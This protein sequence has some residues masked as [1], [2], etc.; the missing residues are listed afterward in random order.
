MVE[1]VLFICNSEQHATALRRVLDGTNIRTVGLGC[2]LIGS[3]FDVIINLVSV[4]SVEERRKEWLQ[5]ALMKVVPGG[6]VI[7][8]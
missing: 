8:I 4:K 1:K 5:F 3:R 6:T 2:A 7:H